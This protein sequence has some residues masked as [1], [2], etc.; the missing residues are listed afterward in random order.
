M[1]QTTDTRSMNT[2]GAPAS[3][4]TAG[5][6]GVITFTNQTKRNALSHDMMHALTKAFAHFAEAKIRVVVLALSRGSKSGPQ[7]MTSP[8]CHSEVWTRCATPTLWKRRSGPSECF[9]AL[10]SPWCMDRCGEAHSIWS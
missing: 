5:N 2:A 6:I 10:S 8:N 7:G 4:E 9:Q 3:I 1:D